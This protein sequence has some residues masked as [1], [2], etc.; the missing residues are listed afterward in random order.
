[1]EMHQIR[2]FVAVA[3]TGSFRIA[4]DQLF[5]TRQAVGSAIQL[6]EEEMGYQLFERTNKGLILTRAAKCFLPRAQQL[7]EVA[8]KLQQD[9]LNCVE[10]T[11]NHIDICFSY[12]TYAMYESAMS[13][14]SRSNERSLTINISSASEQRCLDM[15][16]EGEVD[17]ALSTIPSCESNCR[18]LVEYPICLLMSKDNPLSNLENISLHDIRD[19]IFLAFNSDT[20]APLYVPDSIRYSLDPSKLILSNDLIY[21]FRRVRDNRGILMSVVEN[22]GNLLEGTIFKPFPA[23]GTWKHYLSLSSVAAAKPPYMSAYQQ[24]YNTLSTYTS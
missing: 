11:T 2:Y 15:L 14:F 17:I 13:I 19:E 3:K 6:L 7:I 22:M 1:M 20:E 8:D 23:G 10:R 18:L 4:A 12:T 5:I 9:M 16:R 21:L 24:L